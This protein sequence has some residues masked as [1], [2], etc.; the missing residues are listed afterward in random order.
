MKKF[1]KKK[2]FLFSVIIL[3]IATLVG[4]WFLKA[5]DDKQINYT[6]GRVTRGNITTKIDATGTIN[7]VNYVDV[8]TNVAGELEKVLVH[9]NE[10][11]EK[12]QVIAYIKADKMQDVLLQEKEIM[13][14]KKARYERSKHLYEQGVIPKQNYDD[15]RTNY[16]TAQASY[17]KALKNLDEATILAPISGTIIGNPLQPGQTINPGL[18]SQMII[19]TIADLHDLEIYIAVDETDIGNVHV[20][21]KVTFTVD[22]QS[23]KIFDGVVKEVS[24]GKRGSLGTISNSVVFYTVKVAIN[25]SQVD[26]LLPGMTARATIFGPT[27]KDVLL[28]PLTAIRSDKSGSFVYV[29]KNGNPE[30]TKVVMGMTSDSNVEIISGLQENDEIIVSGNIDGKGDPAAKARTRVR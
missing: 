28:V 13:L 5:G 26:L 2:T 12:G 22:S 19:A 16:M 27:R 6:T 4:W 8:S 25:K 18:S 24:K 3:L 17:D 20:G 10:Q 21:E 23:N 30:K 11:V 14:N 1:Y 9:E 15:D 7:P 29:M